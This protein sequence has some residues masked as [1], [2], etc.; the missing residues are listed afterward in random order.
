MAEYQ[1]TVSGRYHDDPTQEESII[2]LPSDNVRDDLSAPRD[3]W[4]SI[5]TLSLVSALAT[6]F[7]ALT[8]ASL[9]ALIIVFAYRPSMYNG[10]GLPQRLGFIGILV[11]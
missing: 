8:L 4:S 3:F 7:S 10:Y 5:K 2:D 1:P 9:L 6:T 11:S